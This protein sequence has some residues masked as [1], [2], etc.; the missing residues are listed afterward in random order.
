MKN[1]LNEREGIL[2]NDCAISG[3]PESAMGR[4]RDGMPQGGPLRQRGIAMGFG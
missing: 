4:W 1:Q 3:L 2:E